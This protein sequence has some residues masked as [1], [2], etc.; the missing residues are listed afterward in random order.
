MFQCVRNVLLAS[1][2]IALIACKKR[3]VLPTTTYVLL[4]TS[5]ATSQNQTAE[6]FRDAFIK[7][8]EK[9]ENL[10][11]VE[12]DSVDFQYKIR[13]NDVDSRVFY[14]KE[15]HKTCYNNH[16]EVFNLKRILV[17]AKVSLYDNVSDK[18]DSYTRKI[19][20]G[21][22]VNQLK[23]YEA[24][25][26]DY[27]ICDNPYKNGSEISLDEVV[28]KLATSLRYSVNKRIHKIETD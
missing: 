8:L 15:T 7:E 18:I 26:G 3:D 6:I 4:E 13:I 5:K 19:E 17:E 2:C 14:R 16:M 1:F 21:E 22:M 25:D 24:S 28:E 10:F 12:T 11:V 20:D 23:E 27:L 9:T